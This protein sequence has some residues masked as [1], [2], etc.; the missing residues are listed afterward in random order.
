MP[1]GHLP[2][3]LDNPPLSPILREIKKIVT[4]QKIFLTLVVLDIHMYILSLV[5]YSR[6]SDID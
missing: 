1:S 4:L 3:A 2:I 6:A 5:F